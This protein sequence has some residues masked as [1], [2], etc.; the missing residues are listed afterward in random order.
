MFFFNLLHIFYL[1]FFQNAGSQLCFRLFVAHT[2]ETCLNVCELKTP[3]KKASHGL[4]SPPSKW[5]HFCIFLLSTCQCKTPP[6][7]AVQYASCKKVSLISQVIKGQV[8]S[9]WE[10]YTKRKTVQ[11]TFTKNVHM[12]CH[13]SVEPSNITSTTVSKTC[14]CLQK[15][16]KG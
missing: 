6:S 3:S 2:Y 10:K 4:I 16:K 8:V 7:S 5:E 9:T 1:L 13:L 11:T 15:K 12:V 14:S